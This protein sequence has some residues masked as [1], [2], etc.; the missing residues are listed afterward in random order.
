[1]R[2][3]LTGLPFPLS[4]R[5]CVEL[6]RIPL[7]THRGGGDEEAEVEA[8]ASLSMGLVLRMMTRAT[9]SFHIKIFGGT[10]TSK[11]NIAELMS[12]LG[13]WVTRGSGASDAIFLNTTV[14][15]PPHL[16]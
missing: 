6:C 11:M 1:M 12:E 13:R 8:D 2:T 15:L 5:R 14:D 10:C 16:S 3:A 7:C 4:P 9:L